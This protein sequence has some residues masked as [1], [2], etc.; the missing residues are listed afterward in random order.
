MWLVWSLVIHALHDFSS[1]RRSY[2]F[3]KSAFPSGGGSW[4]IV[5]LISIFL[6]EDSYLFTHIVG[7]YT[8]CFWDIFLSLANIGNHLYIFLISTTDLI[9]NILELWANMSG[10]FCHYCS[11]IWNSGQNHYDSA[12]NPKLPDVDRALDNK[13]IVKSNKKTTKVTSVQV[14]DMYQVPKSHSITQHMTP[15]I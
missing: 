11:V 13:V 12:H 9:Y 15:Y 5:S 7:F 4:S 6:V 2:L 8:N 1:I 14:G 10:T 3:G